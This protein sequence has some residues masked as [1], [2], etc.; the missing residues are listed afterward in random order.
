MTAV[1]G[2]LGGLASPHPLE[3]WLP[4]V[5]EPD[6]DAFLVRFCRAFD[7]VLAPIFATLDSLE[8]YVDPRLTADD[9]VP[10]LAHWVAVDQDLGWPEDRM[11]AFI[12][13]AAPLYRR[14]GTSSAIE[15]IVSLFTGAE[16]EVLD[17]GATTWGSQASPPDARGPQALVRVRGQ[18]A[19]WQ[20]ARRAAL[21]RVVREATPAH[22]AVT[23]EVV[24]R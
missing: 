21:E 7:D 10:W 23:V 6:E 5:F 15:R 13:E 20:G 16:V 17:T 24:A 19:D 22:V 2:A 1:R 18:E 9:F 14:W 8:A 12:A 4:D 3:Q 11:R